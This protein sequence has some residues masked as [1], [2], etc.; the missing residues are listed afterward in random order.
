MSFAGGPSTSKQEYKN[1]FGQES[2]SQEQRQHD[3]REQFIA[4]RNENG[5]F[6]AF[7]KEKSETETA[8]GGAASGKSGD[9][10]NMLRHIEQLE[11]KLTAKEKQLSE[12]QQRVE[13]FSARTREG[14]Q[15]A[16]DS[17]M[18][19]WSWRPPSLME[20]RRGV[21]VEIFWCGGTSE[22]HLAP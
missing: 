18:K 15:S 4:A 1:D 12:A 9:M 5:Q 14:M 17:L 2:R 3:T 13:K 19:K 21:S 11:S 6:Q 10:G 20:C 8:H 7:G 16:L 22:Q